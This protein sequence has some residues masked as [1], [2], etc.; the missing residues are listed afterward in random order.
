MI[1]AL[2]SFIM[3]GPTQAAVVV[4][5]ASVVPVLSILG[6]AALALVLLRGGVRAVLLPAVIAGVVLAAVYQLAYG[7]PE[8]VL[9]LIVELWLPV[10]VLS[11]VLRR[12]ASLPLT[13]LVWAGIGVLA[14]LGFHA[15]I[16][17]PVAFWQSTL[18]ALIGPEA[19]EAAAA[20]DGNFIDDVLVYMMTGY[21][22]LAL[23]FSALA[24]LFLGR[25]M[26][27]ILF[28]PGGFRAEFHALDLGR[29]AAIVGA[30]LWAGALFTGPGLVY[31]LSLVVAAAFVLQALS[32]THALVARRGWSPFW[33]GLVYLITPF[34]FRPMALV[35][36]GDALFN[37]RRRW[38]KDDSD[39][40]RSE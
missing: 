8:P 4:G 32:L 16:D 3:R 30:A 22:A 23:M 1:Q 9:Q 2:A 40:S 34:L 21:W 5:G 36:V 18:R 13:V 17:D 35:G 11:E 29:N 14:V 15:L 20:S 7:T 27:A 31:D 24:S 26:Q 33:L 19:L 37:W 10:L 6:A 38:I 39:E 12:T 28:N 25:W